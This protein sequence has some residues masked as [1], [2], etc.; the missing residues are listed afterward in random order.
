MND[1]FKLSRTSL[2][3]VAA[4]FALILLPVV[5]PAQSVS[6]IAPTDAKALTGLSYG[7]WSSVWWQYALGAPGTDPHNP[8]FD[9]TGKGCGA[10]QQGSSPVFFLAGYWNAASGIRNECVVPK[11]KAL[12]FPMVNIVDLHAPGDGLDTPALLWQDIQNLQVTSVY[13]IVDNVKVTTDPTKFRACAGGPPELNC[14]AAFSLRLPAANIFNGAQVSQQHPRKYG[15]AIGGGIYSPAVAD[16]GYLM[17]APLTPG[18]HTVQFGGGLM[19]YGNPVTA[20]VTYN[21]VV[22]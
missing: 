4:L 1:H 8:L 11:G 21:L 6:I 20:D 10:G 14:S 16:G 7:E 12:F 18:P 17:L 3:A 9:L 19:A 22:K 15:L 5:S 13:A 2:I